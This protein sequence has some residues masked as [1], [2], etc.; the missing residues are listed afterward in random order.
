[1]N[2]TAWKP[3]L[4]TQEY[5]G[6]IGES[7]TVAEGVDR[8]EAV[9]VAAKSTAGGIVERD[10]ASGFAGPVDRSITWIFIPSGS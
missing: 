9:G 6:G 7:G 5:C 10:V 3:K 4:T 2:S 1:M 8:K